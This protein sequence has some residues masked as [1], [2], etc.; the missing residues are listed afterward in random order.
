MPDDKQNT[1][2]K[3]GELMNAKSVADSIIST[4][5]KAN[6]FEIKRKVTAMITKYLGDNAANLKCRNEFKR[7]I[8][9]RL[10]KHGVRI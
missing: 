4:T 5:D 3:K 9:I 10:R 6:I 7:A 1:S 2:E 8:V